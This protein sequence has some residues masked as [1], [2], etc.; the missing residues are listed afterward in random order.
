M[1][2]DRAQTSLKATGEWMKLNGRSVYGCT[3]APAGIVAPPNTVLTYH[4][5][6]NRLYVHLL[7]YPLDRIVL[8][9]LDGKVKYAQF[10]HDAS[11]IRFS[12]GTGDEAGSLSLSLPVRKPPVEIPVLEIFLK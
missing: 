7:A 8:P 2:D 6:T 1:F 11:E 9:G 10:L 5:A 3:E 12:A 4:P